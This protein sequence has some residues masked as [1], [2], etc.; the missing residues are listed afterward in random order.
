[1]LSLHIYHNAFLLEQLFVTLSAIVQVNR[2]W[3]M[4]KHKV[5]NILTFTFEAAYI[6]FRSVD[7]ENWNANQDR[8]LAT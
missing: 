8:K 4:R 3:H 7:E 6:Y 5:N 2:I 1:M